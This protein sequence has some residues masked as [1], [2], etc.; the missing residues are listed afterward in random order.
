MSNE[1]FHKQLFGSTGGIVFQAE[2]YDMHGEPLG[3]SESQGEPEMRCRLCECE[4]EE[5]TWKCPYCEILAPLLKTQ[6]EDIQ[7]SDATL[8][9]KET[10]EEFKEEG[11]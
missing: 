9:L 5:V 6:P 2:A 8:R 10:Y 3:L 1:T 4:L 7:Q 11:K